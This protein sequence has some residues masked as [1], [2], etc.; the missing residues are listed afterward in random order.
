M[1]A[2]IL[3]KNCC[4]DCTPDPCNCNDLPPPPRVYDCRC[5][6]FSNVVYNYPNNP[7]QRL[8]NSDNLPCCEINTQSV[9]IDSWVQQTNTR[10]LL[11]DAESMVAGYSNHR[12][13]DFAAG[14]TYVHWSTQK[15]EGFTPYT[16]TNQFTG[17]TKTATRTF[18][19]CL[20]SCQ[21]YTCIDANSG[22]WETEDPEADEV[23][24]ERWGKTDGWDYH[25]PNAINPQT[26][27][28]YGQ[29]AGW[30]SNCI[31]GKGTTN[32]NQWRYEQRWE[33]STPSAW[34]QSSTDMGIYR[35][36]GDRQFTLSDGN[37]SMTQSICEC[38]SLMIS[39]GLDYFG[40]PYSH[41]SA[42]FF[43]GIT[44]G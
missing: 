44:Y 33:D 14:E 11:V 34:T 37:Y 9:T 25:D 4:D 36:I 39:A 23:V 35:L 16:A 12:W 42:N 26:N 13:A 38:G 29:Y 1:T 8:P 32:G 24:R 19:R 31:D 28:P 20:K 5:P 18:E 10:M 43:Y 22:I 15:W 17:E 2:G 6:N 3:S 40:V 21:P 30:Y 41:F 7:D 27:Q